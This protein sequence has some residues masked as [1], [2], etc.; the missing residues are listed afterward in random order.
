MGGETF[1]DGLSNSVINNNLSAKGQ[2]NKAY[3]KQSV[4]TRDMYIEASLDEP[5][6]YIIVAEVD[7]IE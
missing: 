4:A 1:E 2:G 6:D 7:W 3:H 5:G